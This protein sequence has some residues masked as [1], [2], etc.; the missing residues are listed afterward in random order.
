MSDDL[1]SGVCANEVLVHASSALPCIPKQLNGS[2]MSHCA[3]GATVKRLVLF[4][5]VQRYEN[6]PVR[7][8]APGESVD[9]L[10]RGAAH[11]EVPLCVSACLIVDS[12]D[13]CLT[14]WCGL[15][16]AQIGAAER[17][18]CVRHL[19]GSCVRHRV[20]VVVDYPNVM[21][22]SI[23]MLTEGESGGLSPFGLGAAH[24]LGR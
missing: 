2:P 14:A 21:Q 9:L 5:D 7:K 13:A 8:R 15:G 22:N 24:S 6:R 10:G 20:S 18:G 4:H 11:T 19:N 1:G 3:N 23:V 16:K 17:G 12:V